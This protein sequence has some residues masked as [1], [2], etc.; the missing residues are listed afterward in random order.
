[1]SFDP[2]NPKQNES[3]ALFP[4]ENH[5]NMGRLQ[6]MFNADH[7]FN[8]TAATNDGW[9][10]VVHWI[11]QGSDPIDPL[12]PTAAAPTNVGGPAISWEQQDAYS[13]DRVWLRQQ[14]NGNVTGID[15]FNEI[16]VNNFSVPIT[17]GALVTPPDNTYG[18]IYYTLD[19]L[20]G[21]GRGTYWKQGG[22]VYDSA[23]VQQFRKTGSPGVGPVSFGNNPLV[24]VAYI[25]VNSTSGVTFL[26]SFRIIYRYI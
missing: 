23:L 20:G 22:L 13:V 21:V 6:T 5:R 11:Q 16:R 3:P 4:A 1:M 19:A 26:A 17:E 14:N 18:E 12:N 9:H 2:A 8:D 7:Q 15:G 25:T 10:K 24:P